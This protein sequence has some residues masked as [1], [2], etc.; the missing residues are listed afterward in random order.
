MNSR[1]TTRHYFG[2][3]AEV[4]DIRSKMH[5]L[6]PA[7]DL[8]L[9]GCFVKTITPF[10]E[11]TRIRLRITHG[12]LVFEARGHVAHSRVGKGMGIAFAEMELAHQI[13]LDEWLAQ[14]RSREF[15]VRRREFSDLR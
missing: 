10:A 7:T 15:E 5:L 8:S 4:I 14:N 1:R 11:G 2:G 6:A 13:V 12:G 9:F 3:P